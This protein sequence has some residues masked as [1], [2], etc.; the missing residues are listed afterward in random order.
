MIKK[1]LITIT[2]LSSLAFANNVL[3]TDTRLVAQGKAV[4]FIFESSSCPY[5]EVLKKDFK[6]NKEMV[7]L[8]ENRN[9]VYSLLYKYK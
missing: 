6:E 1:L 5:C 8:V 2:L 9:I 7:L 4:M 3:K